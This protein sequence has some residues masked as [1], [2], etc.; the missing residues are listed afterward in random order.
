MLSYILLFMLFLIVTLGIP[1]LAYL[2]PKRLGHPK[3]GI[4]T[5]FVISILI[6]GFFLGTII[7][8]DFF[9]KDSAKKDLAKYNIEL[10]NDFNILD[11]WSTIALSDYYHKFTLNLSEEDKE[12]CINEIRRAKNFKKIGLHE[13]YKPNLKSQIINYETPSVLV[14]KNIEIETDIINVVIIKIYKNT[15]TLEYVTYEEK[16]NTAVTS[17]K[18]KH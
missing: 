3:F 8:D 16:I 14:R 7:K 9:N 2:I 1:A 6:L 13:S 12:N 4:I 17:S 18:R 11:N 10:S 15:S 5:G